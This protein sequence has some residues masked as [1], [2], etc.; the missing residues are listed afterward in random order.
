MFEN[1]I[2][3]IIST[4]SDFQTDKKSIFITSSF[5]TQSLVLLKT[6]SEYDKNIPIYFINTGYHFPETI[7]YKQKLTRFFELNVI[8]VYSETPLIDQ[9]N[10]NNRLLYTS[11]TDHC[12]ELNKTKPLQKIINQH[13][14]WVTGIRRDQTQ[15]RNTANEIED[16]GS[17]KY[18]YNP[19]LDWTGKDIIN[20]IDYY[21]LPK[22]PLD[23]DSLISIG[24]QPCTR[25]INTSSR[26]QNRWYGQTKTECG[27]HIN[28]KEKA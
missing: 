15:A 26:D 2:I 11:D 14:V 8:D 3:H 10:A 28:F 18:K 13:D 21:R 23:H 4:L 22:H 1:R 24:C 16:L 17:R 25:L 6:I 5:Q 9:L 12:C 20:Y 27:L 7:L 19:L